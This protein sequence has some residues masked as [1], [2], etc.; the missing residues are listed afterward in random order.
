MP[1]VSAVHPGV[2]G[3][4]DRTVDF[5]EDFVVLP[6]QTADDTDRGWGEHSGGNDDRLLAER[7]PH[8]D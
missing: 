6:E 7:P 2:R 5:G 1:L 3:D 4:D 8:W